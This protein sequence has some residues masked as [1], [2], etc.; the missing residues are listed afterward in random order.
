MGNIITRHCTAVVTVVIVSCAGH[1]HS[2]WL[3]RVG[4]LQSYPGEGFLVGTAAA[5]E[6]KVRRTWTKKTRVPG[7][8]ITAFFQHA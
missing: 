2:I 4:V 1:T 8:N 3:V 5:P 7:W 6:G